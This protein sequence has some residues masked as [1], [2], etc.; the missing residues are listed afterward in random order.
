MEKQVISKL[1]AIMVLIGISL[2][3]IESYNFRSHGIATALNKAE[4]ISEVVKN[5]LTS[6]MINGNMDQRDIFL[7]SISNIKNVESIWI[8]RGKNVVKQYGEG[9][10]LEKPRD[11]IDNSVLV[12]GK[13]EY[14]LNESFTK[15]TIRVTIPYNADT[16]SSA[17]C[18]ECHNVNPGEPL[19]AVSIIMDMSDIKD[20]GL[21][22]A[23]SI[24]VFTIIA[25]LFVLYFSNKTLKP[26]L[27]TIDE[28]SGKVKD[29]S[30]GIF[31][32]I[33]SKPGLSNESE[34]LIK[35]Y[36]M[37]V[38]GLNTTFSDIDKKLSIFVGDQKLYTGNPLLNSQRIVG[39]LSDIYQ[40]KKEIEVDRTKDEIYKRLSQILTN[41]FNIKYF[42]F[43][44]LDYKTNKTKIVYQRGNRDYCFNMIKENSE[45]CRVSRQAG[46]VCSVKDHKACSSFC[47]NVKFH[48]CTSF[49]IGDRSVLIV[50][51]VFDDERELDRIK[52]HI[53]L[54]R[55]YFIE[56][57]PSLVVKL[58]LEALK[59]SAFKDGLTGLY[60]RKFLDEHLT[61]LVPQS[62]RE[63]INIGVLMLDMDH[64]K[65]VND[66]YGHDVGD[67]VL[68]ELARILDESVRDSD[69]VVRYGGEEFVVLLVGIKDEESAIEVANKIRTNVSKNE[70]NIYA[71]NKLRKT[72]SC[73]I[74]M[75]PQDSSNFDIVMKN[76]DI[77]LYEAKESGRDKVIRFVE[78]EQIELF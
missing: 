70:I 26:H 30:N 10:L 77:A 47:S 7:S 72:V 25:I 49:D 15:T 66:E 3:L 67:I 51:F 36:N 11:N 9:K 12:T 20:S 33:V 40:F 37:L 54:I 64:F 42:T 8:I 76:A 28:L 18:F 6:H 60:N 27:E 13:R 24:I 63:G 21:T 45:L 59:E 43:M 1:I 41:K 44:E 23:F 34:N 65:A 56:A 14:S 69:I 46:D 4:S 38:N 57:I 71:G 16:K 19:G 5:G 73:G 68:K 29:M 31:T 52:T 50:N 78:K 17:N 55:N 58:L 75:F 62:L 74:S 53:S 32:N 48:Y 22:L 35:E 61:K 2:T 39:N